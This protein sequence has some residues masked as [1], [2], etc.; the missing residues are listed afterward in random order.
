MNRMKKIHSNLRAHE[1]F[2]TNVGGIC[3]P[4]SCAA[5][6]SF[7]SG[8]V[9]LLPSEIVFIL[10]S[11]HGSGLDPCALPCRIGQHY[12]GL[13][14]GFDAGSIHDCVEHLDAASHHGYGFLFKHFDVTGFLRAIDHRPRMAFNAQAREWPA[15]QVKRIMTESLT[16]FDPV[17][18]RRLIY[19]PSA[20]FR[21]RT[22]IFICDNFIASGHPSQRRVLHRHG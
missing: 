6:Y 11:L 22:N 16:R 1:R 14:I 5:P 2:T 9:L 20:I 3:R 8:P 17:I 7:G 18:R 12:G 21:D 4:Y 19:S 15:C 13:P 10:Q